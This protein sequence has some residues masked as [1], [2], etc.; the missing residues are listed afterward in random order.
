MLLRRIT[1]HIKTQNWFAVLLDFL[2]VV[3]GVFMGIQVNNWNNERLLR[4]EET[5][6]IQRMIDD[7]H[8][9]IDASEYEASVTE[10]QA[11]Q[12]T[13]VL[14]S[15][16]A[17]R[18]EIASRADFAQG[19]YTLGKFDSIQYVRTVFDELKSTGKMGVIS[20]VEL[21]NAISELEREVQAHISA[22]QTIRIWLA[23]HIHY[24]EQRV[25]YN[26]TE[27]RG[28]NSPLEWQHLNLNLDDVCE[29]LKF[30]NSVAAVRNHTYVWLRWSRSLIGEMKDIKAT[31]EAEF[32]A[33]TGSNS[34]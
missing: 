14:N 23:P 13:I 15:L 3:I 29:D 31:L 1:E 6:F 10:R 22:T 30:R 16:D 21:R 26:V 7:F 24:I 17:C 27:P 33:K 12:A 4:A 32:V 28:G 5:F 19:I 11:K 18:V 25:R 2:I 20:N 9:S 34:L 8:A